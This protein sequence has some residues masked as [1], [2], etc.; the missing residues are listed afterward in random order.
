MTRA[1]F[2]LLVLGLSTV[3]PQEAGF[4]DFDAPLGTHWTASVPSRARIVASGDSAHGNVLALEPDGDDVYVL[5]KRTDRWTGG[6]LEGDV[7]FPSREDNYL[8]VIYGFRRTPARTDFGVVY[9][10]GNESYAQ[11]NPHYD[12]ND[13]RTLYP[14]Y[15]V[16]LVGPAATVTL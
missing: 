7:R 2:T 4:D 8:G 13:S 3:R 5:L 10:K 6:A 12:F 16:P 15:R 14:D 11:A 1:L 9:I